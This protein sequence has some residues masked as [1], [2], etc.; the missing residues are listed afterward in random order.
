M[1]LGDHVT[2]RDL[3]VCHRSATDSLVRM[4]A[5]LLLQVGA[6]ILVTGASTVPMFTWLDTGVIGW[7]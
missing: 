3:Q 6:I 5:V 4:T 1:V 2:S 7:P